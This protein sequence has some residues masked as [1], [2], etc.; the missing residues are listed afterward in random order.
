MKKLYPR[1]TS[2]AFLNFTKHAVAL[3]SLS[4]VL[5]CSKSAQFGFTSETNLFK[6]NESTLSKKIDILWVIDNSGSMGTSQKNLAKNISSFLTDFESHNFD[7]QM[8]VTTTDSWLDLYLKDSDRS[9]LR[10]GSPWKKTGTPIMGPKTP[11]FR[12]NFVETVQQGIVGDGDERAFQSIRTTLSN[13]LNSSFLRKDS[14]LAIVIISDEDDRSIPTAAEAVKLSD[15]ES[16]DLTYNYLDKLTRSNYSL[17]MFSVSAITVQDDACL[18]SIY[19]GTQ[20]IG[21]RYLDMVDKTRGIS[22]SLCGDFGESLSKISGRLLE[23]LTRFP[24]SRKPDV[25]TLNILVDSKVVPQSDTDG[26]SYDVV[27]NAISFHGSQVPSEGSTIK[28]DFTPIEIK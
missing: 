3:S 2:S 26:W 27:T 8:A 4:L 28:V 13:P 9:S 23:L 19:S 21:A 22:G 16:P 18:N 1:K 14:Y 7:F 5:G 17:P 25:K 24:L 6:Q 12:D 15:L 20:K 11:N 10:D